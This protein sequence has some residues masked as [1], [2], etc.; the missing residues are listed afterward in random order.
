MDGLLEFRIIQTSK[1]NG[2]CFSPFLLIYHFG[3]IDEMELDGYFL[4]FCDRVDFFVFISQE[5]FTLKP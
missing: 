3:R 5:L 4:L 1:S 2:Q